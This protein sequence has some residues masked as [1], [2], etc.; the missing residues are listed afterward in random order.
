TTTGTG[1]AA[2]SIVGNLSTSGGAAGTGGS[3]GAQGTPGTFI[4]NNA[5]SSDVISGVLA[6]TGPSGNT[7]GTLTK[8]G[9]GFVTLSNTN[10]YNGATTISAGTLQT[11]STS[12]IPANSNVLI[13]SGG[14]LNGSGTFTETLGTLTLSGNATITYTSGVPQFKFANSSSVSW[15]SNLL[16]VNGWTGTGGS[17]GSSTGG[18]LFFATSTAG[19]TAGQLTAI[20]F[21]SYPPGASYVTSP[22]TTGEVVPT[23][24][25]LIINTTPATSIT[26]I[27]ATINGT[28]INSGT[29]GVTGSFDYGAGNYTDHAGVASIPSSIPATGT[30]NDSAFTVTSLIPNTLYQ[31][32]ANYIIGGVTTN[33]TSGLTFVTLPT[34][35]TGITANTPTTS[36]FTVSWTAPSNIGGAL[37]T[38]YKYNVYVSTDNITYTL[39]TGGASLSTN[40]ASITGLAP[41]TV[42][43]YEVQTVST[44]AGTQTSTF[45][46]STAENNPTTIA[47]LSALPTTQPTTFTSNCPQVTLSWSAVTG[48]PTSGQATRIGYI[49]L[50]NTGGSAPVLTSAVNRYAPY[51]T[52]FIA[53]LPGGVSIID[54]ISFANASLPS[55]TLTFND[56]VSVLGTYN[57]QLIPYTFDGTPGDSTYN[58]FTT[59]AKQLSSVSVIKASTWLGKNTNWNDPTNWCGGSIPTA[60]TNIIIPTGLVNY[61]YLGTAGLSTTGYVD[62]ISLGSG[63]LLTIGTG[64]SL[65]I[66]GNIT[67]TGGTFNATTGTI[68]TAGNT[69]QIIVGA[70]FLNQ[71]IYNLLDSTTSGGLSIDS[72]SVIGELGFPYSG[73]SSLTV[74]NKLVLVSNATTTAWVGPIT[75]VGGIPQATITGKVIVQRYFPSHRRWRLITGPVTVGNAQ[76]INAAWQEGVISVTGVSN[77]NPLPGYGTHIS[78]PKGGAYQSGLGYDQTPTNNPSIG[79][80]KDTSAWGS[81]PNTNVTKVTDYQGYMLFVRG[82]RDYNIATTTQSTIATNAT[83]RTTGT[84]KTGPQSVTVS[85]GPNVIGNPYASTINF[86]S[87]YNRSTSVL[88]SNPAANNTF[89]LWDPNIAST[90]N[91]SANGT[92]GWIV[93][94][95]ANDGTGNYLP[96]PDPRAVS[97]F[98]VNGD[99]QS[100]AAFIVHALSAGSVLMDEADKVSPAATN[101]DLYLFRPT[102]NATPVTMLRTTLY[103]TAA[104]TISYVADGVLNMFDSSYSNDVDFS[105]DIQKQ[106]N[107]SEECSIIKSGRLLAVQRS[108]PVNA[109]DTIYLQL[110][111]INQIP[112]RF[113]FEATNFN[114]PDLN[115][116]LIDTLMHTTTPISLGDSITNINFTVTSTSGSANRFAITFRPAP[117][118]VTFNAVTATVTQQNK[119]ILVQWTVSNQLNINEYIVEK[120]TDG[121][122]F[123][124]VDTT[125]ATSGNTGSLV[126]DWVD[127]NPVIGTNYY[128]IRSIDNTGVIEHSPTAQAVIGKGIISGIA[129]YPNP[130]ID[131]AIGLQINN[132]P[133]GEYGIRII[134]ASGQ[135]LLNETINHGTTSETKNI[136]L[137]N[138]T[139]KGVYILEVQSPDN[140]QTKIKFVNQ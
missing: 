12:S 50:R 67:N 89:Y 43:Y 65:S 91:S 82:A 41:N 124:P 44:L 94:T 21:S 46:K 35:P 18:K 48:L 20:T 131:G 79:Y 117:G 24:S 139:A 29:L 107:L 49:I 88:G 87:I 90:I 100:G 19:L 120:S 26:T 78:G 34:P 99:I 102:V 136:F 122:N 63:A 23:G 61:P 7:S 6:A 98:D 9:S 119:S 69:A 40:T 38:A 33:S 54:S 113:T 135:V 32:R 112:Y 55:G 47:T 75:E 76:T 118:S 123:Y 73:V 13:N 42:Y 92:G 114:R 30:T 3:G 83:L 137:N 106:A 14:T 51:S 134:D 126:Y 28:M 37:G 125:L 110:A 16:T 115:A 104:D 96:V 10:T 121:V 59:G 45:D 39:A 116:Y 62:S 80:V 57:Y 68:V 71:T 74:S 25:R 127:A 128:Q 101:N 17:S 77:P 58:Y 5:G 52:K 93:L 103:A 109:G 84:L 105:K 11:V 36:S 66:S 56:T 138:G 2:L 133:T 15:G 81:L 95:S 31:F 72:I 27:S 111:R 130:V 140:S 108:L 129:I 53:N 8:S 60:V 22:S 4:I 1:A 70:N 97:P 85:A 132:M 86:N 64:G